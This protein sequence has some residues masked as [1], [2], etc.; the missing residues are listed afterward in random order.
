M[1]KIDI[2]SLDEAALM[3]LHD[4]IVDRLHFLHRQKTAQ[5]LRQI[6]IGD[7]VMFAGPDDN[8]LISGIV[9]RRNRKTVSIHADDGRRWN[10]SPQLILITQDDIRA[11]V[12]REMPFLTLNDDDYAA[13]I[14][15]NVPGAGK[16]TSSG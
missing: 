9:I 7:R 3:E 1:A 13:W 10:V 14:R 6:K 11:Q 16:L 4:Q 12:E 8:T 15:A 2:D 5:A